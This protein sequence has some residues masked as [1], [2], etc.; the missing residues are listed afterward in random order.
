[1]ARNAEA[2]RAEIYRAATAEFA[3]HGIAGAR[4]DRIA[5]AA[6]F[7]KNL[8]YV[9]FGNKEQLFQSVM[10]RYSERLLEAAPFTPE[11]LDDYAV[12]LFDF[13]LNNP[14]LVRL[15]V[16]SALEHRPLSERAVGMYEAKLAGVA[17]AQASGHVTPD[18]PPSVVLSLVNAIATA[19]TVGT[20]GVNVTLVAPV[21]PQARRAA[22]GAS[23]RTLLMRGP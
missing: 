17:A 6:G 7:N 14:D 5:S 22:I 20:Y 4:V 9:Y 2:S 21:D 11:T 19:W 16:W 8:I 13:T 10:V 18:F 1:M 23:V 15:S 12:A 3:A